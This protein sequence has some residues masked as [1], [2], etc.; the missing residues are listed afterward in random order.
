M[1][2]LERNTA[3]P[4]GNRERAGRN[5]QPTTKSIARKRLQPVPPLGKSHL[6]VVPR[7]PVTPADRWAA[8]TRPLDMETALARLFRDE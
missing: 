5:S 6:P 8:L 4:D 3:R 7:P 2:L 1:T